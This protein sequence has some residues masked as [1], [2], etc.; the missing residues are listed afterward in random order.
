M[1]ISEFQRTIR[2]PKYS[3]STKK[4]DIA[5]VEFDGVI[6]LNDLVR[7]ACIRTTTDDPPQSQEMLIA[8]WGSI[9][10]DRMC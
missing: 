4:N 2:H 8:G 1:E 7:P 6:E 9:E 5:L 10:A 3:V